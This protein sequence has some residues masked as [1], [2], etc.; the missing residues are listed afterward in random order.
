ML[1]GLETEIG[2]A[3]DVAG[4]NDVSLVDDEDIMSGTMD[5]KT[6]G[7]DDREMIHR[8]GVMPSTTATS[9]HAPETTMHENKG[10]WERQ[11]SLPSTKDILIR[12]I[13]CYCSRFCCDLRGIP[14]KAGIIV[15]SVLT[16]EEEEGL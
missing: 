9:P 8:L 3:A 1:T 2:K 5:P 10:L 15:F 4:F 6:S 14:I 13:S 11:D 16:T 12:F 7:T